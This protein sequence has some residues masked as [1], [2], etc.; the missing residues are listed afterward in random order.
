[1]IYRDILKVPEYILFDPTEDYLHPSLQGFRLA[2]EKYV[3]IDL[4]A[5]RLPSEVLGLQLERDGTRLRLFDPVAQQY[6]LTR[7]EAREIAARRAVDADRRALDADRRAA[8]ADR[9]AAD[10]EAA[11]RRFAEENERLKREIEGLRG[12]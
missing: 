3:P 10:A 7:L 8:D 9:R 5:G 6:L 4:V 12:A 2:A 11:Q 1:M